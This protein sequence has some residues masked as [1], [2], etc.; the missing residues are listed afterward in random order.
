MHPLVHTWVRERP[1]MT[2]RAQAVWCEAALHILSRCV[3]LPPLHESVVHGN[4]ARKL[5]SHIVSVGK[6][7]VKIE[8]EF[9]SN[10]YK[11]NRPWPALQSS[12]SP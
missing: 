3:L 1:Q 11:R 10:R 5:R 2:A 12:I 9:A 4:L 7:Q 6:F 8:Q